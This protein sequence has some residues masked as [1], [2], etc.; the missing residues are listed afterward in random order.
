MGCIYKLTSPSGKIYIGQTT[1]SFEQRFREHCCKSKGNSIIFNALEKYG[2]EKFTKE[3]L[4]VCDND[5]LDENEM[6]FIKKFECLEPKGYNIRTGG[7]T[8]K[9]SDESKDRMRQ[10]KIGSKN[11]NYGVPRSDKFKTIMKQKKSGKNHHFFGKQL[12]IQHKES[13]SKSH[14]K[15]STLPMY[16]VSIKPRPEVNSQGGYAV[17]NHPILKNKYFTSRKFTDEEKYKLALNYFNS[18]IEEGSTTK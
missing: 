15:D 8:G 4:L 18:Y 13:L 17:V 11:P 6:F 1:R 2:A 9:H 14:K 12:S 10:S 7:S 3:I 16:L 5:L